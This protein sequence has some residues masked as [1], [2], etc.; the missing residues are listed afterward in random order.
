MKRREFIAATL[1][2][3]II[4]VVL[5]AANFVDYEPG[6][7]EKALAEGKTVFVD[8]SSKWCSTCKRQDRGINAL[9]AANPE[10]DAAMTFVKV[11]WNIYGNHPVTQ[12]RRVP[13]RPTLLVPRGD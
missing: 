4:P 1:A 12:N 5:S 13:R 11:D 2:A 3:S 8:Y 9:R 10:D 6:V 7:I